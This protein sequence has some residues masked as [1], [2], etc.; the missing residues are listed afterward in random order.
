MNLCRTALKRC[1][2]G[3]HRSIC[4]FGP[5]AG[6]TL[7]ELLVVIAI[8]AILA[9]ML[10]PALARAKAKAKGT[11]CLSNMKQLQFCYHMYCGDNRDYLPPNG[12]P[13]LP[14]SWIAGNAQTD[15]TS[16]NI[17]QGLLY[18]Y[19]RNYFIYRCPADTFSIN[20]PA[21]LP[22]HPKPYLAP[23]TR[24]Y[25]INY[26]LGGFTGSVPEGSTFN[27]VTSLVKYNNIGLPGF[28][29]M[30]AFVDENEH[31]IDDGCFGIYSVS[32]GQK[33]WWNLPASRHNNGCNFSFAD[34][35]SESWKWHGTAVL[36]YVG[37]YQ[38]PDNSD[39]LPRVMA[40]TVP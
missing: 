28:A 9:S 38:A 12:S 31:S 27:G 17:E 35:H 32:S 4:K 13:A 34:G 14:N 40:G 10:L 24:S 8:I 22:D 25:S 5:V 15:T 23:Q 19:N 18:Q 26:A 30:I 21:H 20:A 2:R 7:I 29:Q 39:D 1:V 11:Q 37:P 6:F 3:N 33:K 36:T 16:V